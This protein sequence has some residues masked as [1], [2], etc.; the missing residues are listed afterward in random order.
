[1]DWFE[2][3]LYPGYRQGFLVEKVLCRRTTAHHELVIFESQGF[4][5]VMTLDGIVQTTEADEFVYHEMLAHVP[6]FGHGAVR[7]VLVVGGGDGG[8]LEEVLKHPVARATLVEIDP[9]VIELARR[10]LSSICGGAF[11]DPRA[12]VV[13]ADAT[14]YV[15]E[16]ERRFD[17]IIVDSTDPVGPGAALFEAPFYAGCKRCLRPGGVLAA[18]T[19]VPFLQPEE[20]TATMR[21]LQALFADV[22]A[23]LAPVPSY[24]GGFM[25]FAWASDDPGK[26][27]IDAATLNSRVA[28]AKVET[29]YYTADIH[30][31]AFVL[32]GYIRAL[33]DE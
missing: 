25:A 29:R 18:Q 16:T 14:R 32:P 2:E 8:M 27:G 23:F 4:G 9:A 5:R 12:E 11:D 10:Y 20:L 6:I 31:A 21:H 17:V 19:G 15:A 30:Q 3:T 22:T 13:V 28:D 24:V 7:E 26:R 33:M 1:M